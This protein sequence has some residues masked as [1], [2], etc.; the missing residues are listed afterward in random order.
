M[1]CCSGHCYFYKLY[2]LLFH[3]AIVTRMYLS[4]FWPWGI[5]PKKPK[6][7]LKKKLQ[8]Q[9]FIWR[10]EFILCWYA[11]MQLC[12]NSWYCSFLTR[13]SQLKICDFSGE[14]LKVL[15]CYNFLWLQRQHNCSPV[16]SFADCVMTLFLLK[17]HLQTFLFIPVTEK[18]QILSSDTLVAMSDMC[19]C[20]CNKECK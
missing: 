13:V 20:L 7:A 9:F 5:K 2:S 15:K 14:T 8:P 4:Q 10:S 1:H 12:Y 3:A 16:E 11:V 19:L 17:V 18:C 6:V